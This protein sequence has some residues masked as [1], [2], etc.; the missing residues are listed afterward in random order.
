M[1]HRKKHIQLTQQLEAKNKKKSKN[2]KKL[3]ISLGSVILM[4]GATYGL[5]VSISAAKNAGN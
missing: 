4:A 3:F 1:E 5:M 2:W